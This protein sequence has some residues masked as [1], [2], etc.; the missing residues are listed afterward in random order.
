MRTGFRLHDALDAAC[1]VYGLYGM[2]RGQASLECNTTPVL[3]TLQNI[4]VFCQL[5]KSRF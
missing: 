2:H 4:Q 1:F 5:G 3:I